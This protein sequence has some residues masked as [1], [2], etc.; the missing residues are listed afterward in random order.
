[1]RRKAVTILRVGT[2]PKYAS[3]WDKAFSGETKKKKIRSSTRA[4]GKKKKRSQRS[5]A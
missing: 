3:N 2:T 5:G 4:S 1:M